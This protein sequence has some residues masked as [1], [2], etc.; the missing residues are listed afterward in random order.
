[1]YREDTRYE[2]APPPKRR[3]RRLGKANRAE[4]V[5]CTALAAGVIIA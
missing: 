5:L 4:F 1:M 3:R 2:Q